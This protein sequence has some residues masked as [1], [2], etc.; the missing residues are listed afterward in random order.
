MENFM[1]RIYEVLKPFCLIFVS[2]CLIVS[3]AS[4]PSSIKASF[5]S[6]EVYMEYSC[7]QLSSELSEANES[8][9]KF[10]K[11]QE[12]KANTDAATVLFAVV[13]ASALTGDFAKEVSTWKGIVQAINSAQNKLKCK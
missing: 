13:P 8:L 11:L 4:R 5:V 9:Q 2:L 3:C 10:S 7:L 6:D 12:S 1:N